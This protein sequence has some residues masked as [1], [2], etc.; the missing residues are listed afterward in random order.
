MIGEIKEVLGA[1]QSGSNP[2][3]S[4][5]LRL[6]PFALTPEFPPSNPLASEC[7]DRYIPI[8]PRTRETRDW[9]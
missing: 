2:A 1:I 7:N 3:A 5:V 8:W 6:R 4:T 9:E